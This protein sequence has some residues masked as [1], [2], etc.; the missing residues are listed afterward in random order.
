MAPNNANKVDVT[1]RL[2]EEYKE[3]EKTHPD[4]SVLYFFTIKIL[5]ILY[6]IDPVY[7]SDRYWTRIKGVAE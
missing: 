5:A 1:E 2:K 6:I 7:F 4:V 3:W